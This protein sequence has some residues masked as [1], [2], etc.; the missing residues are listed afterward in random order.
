VMRNQCIIRCRLCAAKVVFWVAWSIALLSAPGC[1]VT[2]TGNAAGAPTVEELVRRYE[3]AHRARD[4]DMLR[5]ILW[6]E[7]PQA[8]GRR[9]KYLENPMVEL[10]DV[11]LERV[12]YVEGPPP[13][14]V[15]GAS[16]RYFRRRPGK[17]RQIPGVIGPVFGKLILVGSVRIGG[18]KR[19]VRVDPS[20]VVMQSSNR[21]YI[22]VH[23]MV[24]EDA[25]TSI[26]TGTPSQ[27]EPIPFGTDLRQV[28]KGN[29]R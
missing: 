19:P 15:Y 1:D 10:F 26:R 9:R 29:G 21:Y 25:V 16:V 2:N 8:G 5:D 7:S 14:P 28:I 24:L 20:Y 4:V 17:K 3:A 13:D 22:D 27:S 11:E 18:E 6:W 23:E 12:E